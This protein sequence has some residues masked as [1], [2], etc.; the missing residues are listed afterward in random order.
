MSADFTL[1]KSLKT[2]ELTSNAQ[3]STT[4]TGP[5]TT[6]TGAANAISQTCR[7]QQIMKVA[8]LSATTSEAGEGEGRVAPFTSVLVGANLTAL[9][10]AAAASGSAYS[11]VSL[12]KVTAASNYATHVLMATANLANVAVSQWTPIA[13][14]L[15]SNAANYQ[16]APGD[17]VTANVALTSTGTANNLVC[18]VD[19]VAEDI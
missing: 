15:V 12:Y 18:A 11:V 4:G 10:G 19:Y 1:Y 14:S 3:F 16:L 8:N 5:S 2:S 17:V 6:V 9:S 13:F 7:R